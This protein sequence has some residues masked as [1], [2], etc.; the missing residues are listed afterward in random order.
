MLHGKILDKEYFETANW[1]NSLLYEILCTRKS[2]ELIDSD[3]EALLLAL[4][5]ISREAIESKLSDYQKES[6]LF[7]SSLDLESFSF[8]ERL[9]LIEK[10]RVPYFKNSGFAIVMDIS[11]SG[12]IK[13]GLKAAMA[14]NIRDFGATIRFTPSNFKF[15]LK[16]ESEPTPRISFMIT[17]LPA[18]EM[19]VM[20]RSQQLDRATNLMK[21]LIG[22]FIRNRLC[23][24]NYL[25]VLF[26]QESKTPNLPFAQIA[27]AKQFQSQLRIRL[28]S[29]SVNENNPAILP[30]EELKVMAVLSFGPDLVCKT[31]IIDAETSNSRLNSIH[32]F[33]IFN[34]LENSPQILQIV[35]YQ[36]FSNK[37]G[38]ADS[39]NQLGRIEI[40]YSSLTPGI[41]DVRTVALSTDPSTFIALEMYLNEM[42]EDG[43]KDAAWIF[44][45]GPRPPRRK[46]ATDRS[47][48]S[49]NWE[50]IRFIISKLSTD[51]EAA[52][53]N[54][55]YE[56]DFEDVDE[57]YRS[58]HNN[59]SFSSIDGN[60][61]GEEE[62]KDLNQ[63]NLLAVITKV[64]DKTVKRLNRSYADPKIVDILNALRLE[65]DDFSRRFSLNR[66]ALSAKAMVAHNQR[67]ASLIK[68]LIRSFV[69]E[70]LRLLKDD[71]SNDSL[72][73][74]TDLEKIVSLT[75]DASCVEPVNESS[76]DLTKS[77]DKDHDDKSAV[78]QIFEGFY[79]DFPVKISIEEEEGLKIT[80]N[81]DEKKRRSLD[82][83]YEGIFYTL[84][85]ENY[86]KHLK[87]SS[88]NLFVNM[89]TWEISLLQNQF[90]TF[91][92]LGRNPIYPQYVLDLDEV[93]EVELIKDRNAFT[94][95]FNADLN[96]KEALN[97]ANNGL[98][99]I[100]LRNGVE[101]IDLF[102]E[103]RSCDQ[104]FLL[105]SG[106]IKEEKSFKFALQEIEKIWL[107]PLNL[108]SLGCPYA[109]ALR[110]NS[111]THILILDNGAIHRAYCRLKTIW[112]SKKEFTKPAKTNSKRLTLPTSSPSSSVDSVN[113]QKSSLFSFTRS[114]STSFLSASASAS[115][116]SIASSSSDIFSSKSRH[117][118]LRAQSSLVGSPRPASKNLMMSSIDEF[119][120]STQKWPQKLTETAAVFACTIQGR[121]PGFIA[122]GTEFASFWSGQDLVLPFQASEKTNFAVIPIA[123]IYEVT[124]STPNWVSSFS[125]IVLRLKREFNRFGDPLILTGFNSLQELEIVHDQLLGM[126]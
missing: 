77:N 53:D 81:Y 48:E 96:V 99:R 110:C 120:K 13:V 80:S 92:Q 2:R 87:L 101:K 69:P 113:S 100:H 8:G 106:R 76:P 103:S 56:D 36:V 30:A 62:E 111:F 112:L 88:S 116:D 4:T 45:N 49:V 20:M 78:S 60:E 104:W 89:V 31:E 84:P 35:I 16:L 117:D 37:F 105:I 98:L 115:A 1:L 74:I 27:N 123:A 7:L 22:N 41:L 125:G 40:P 6:W 54:I 9:P 26:R 118:R 47:I 29:I 107:L 14:M 44:W 19:S 21:L 67:L 79:G 5:R 95:G 38:G 46:L 11:Y 42:E 25:T 10:I 65:L 24:P 51:T 15:I 52:D 109:L 59:S 3:Q 39:M 108:P 55:I 83:D 86:T 119:Y 90:I 17:D 97:H 23:F 102:G 124:K 57:D 63:N 58:L 70:A 34:G 122:V 61:V 28:V 75:I 12:G 72:K 94:L 82:I 93:S 91:V 66:P 71:P 126:Q 33:N 50:S 68:P 64:L 114:F 43:E 32:T 18:Y 121:S 73:S 85:Q